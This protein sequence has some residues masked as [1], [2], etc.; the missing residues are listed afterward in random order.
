MATKAEVPPLKGGAARGEGC[1][2]LLCYHR[3]KFTAAA[4]DPRPQMSLKTAGCV[5]SRSL[6]TRGRRS[7]SRSPRGDRLASTCCG[8][9]PE[10]GCDGKT[11][12]QSCGGGSVGSQSAPVGGNK[13]PEE[14]VGAA[15]VSGVRGRSYFTN[16]APTDQRSYLWARYHDMK[17][18]VHGECHTLSCVNL[19][20]VCPGPHALFVLQEAVCSFMLR[21]CRFKRLGLWPGLLAT[22]PLQPEAKAANMDRIDR[23]CIPNG[24]ESEDDQPHVCPHDDSCTCILREG[25]VRV[26]RARTKTKHAR[27]RTRCTLLCL[28]LKEQKK[29]RMSELTPNVPFQCI[30]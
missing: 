17:R 13:K 14:P 22:L 24:K 12:A 27:Y 23:P 5:L 2:R 3:F 4:A 15:G 28:H 26:Q 6:W 11:K 21:F 30:F 19:R 20:C 7:S 10:K 25:E 18:L 8:S 29:D 1:F 16:A 9:A